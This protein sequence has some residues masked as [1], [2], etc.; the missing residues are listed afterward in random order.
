MGV[1]AWISEATSAWMGGEDP[2]PLDAIEVTSAS[3]A[4]ERCGCMRAGTPCSCVDDRPWDSVVRIG[5][6]VEP[7]STCLRLGKYGRNERCLVHIGGLLGG[8][9]LP[10]VP[11][12]AVIVP[13]P[14]PPL[15]RAMRGIDH[16]RVLATAVA[17]VGRWRMRRLL[18]RR[19]GSPQA[20]RSASERRDFTD[21]SMRLTR[22]VVP[23]VVVL[24][25]DVLTSGRTAEVAAGLL[26]GRGAGRIVLAVAAV[27]EP[28][29]GQKKEELR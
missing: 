14:M 4:C 12:G 8:A 19:G 3:S 10:L 21:S 24:V 16:A 2:P 23:P 25:D 27:A 20:G 15:R 1:Q 29:S 5:P 22:A 11:D 6:Y 7:L 18:R 28:A 26:R 9:L 13:V 17:R